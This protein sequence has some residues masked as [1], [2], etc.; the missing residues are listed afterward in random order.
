MKSA[1]FLLITAHAAFATLDLDQ[2]HGRK[3]LSFEVPGGK[4]PEICVIPDHLRD[5]DY[6]DKDEKREKA[7]CDLDF[8][9][10]AAVCPKL[11]STNPGLDIHEIP[12][13]YTLQQVV[14][15]NCVIPDPN[16]D[17]KAKKQQDLAKKV[18]KYKLSTSCSYTPSILSYYHLSRELG[19]ILNVPVAVLRTVDLQNH[20]ALG[21]KAL[22][23]AKRTDVIYQTWESLMHQLTLGSKAPK[24]D[25]LLTSS[26]DQSYGAVVEVPKEDVFYKEFF[27]G[28]ANG[29]AR[30]QNLAVKNPIIAEL[31]KPGP[32]TVD[33][34]FNQVNLQRLIQLRDAANMI[35]IDTLLSQEDRIGNIHFYEK[36]FYLDDSSGQTILKSV[37]E[38]EL[39]KSG[40]EESKTIKV[41]EMLLKD[42]DCGVN[43]LNLMSKYG[44]PKKIAHI[45]PLVYQRLLHLNSIAD[46][47]ETKNFFANETLFT[48][49]DY[50]KFRESLRG[51][52]DLLHGACVAKRLSLDLDL[53][54][55]FTGSTAATSCEQ[56]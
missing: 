18:A 42:N 14:D 54:A 10:T 31:S 43:R 25:L 29:E 30:I 11:N 23:E 38:K 39:K 19:D 46:Q 16:A 9:T 4:R 55:Y 24:K 56:D 8:Y 20:I 37:T 52:T 5:A 28:G 15:K 27:N 17:P 1:L 6:G 49:S 51:L 50:A 53:Q 21:T 3:T 48:Q 44:L 45:D 26:M 13:G 47:D 41:R 36:Y 32:L 12:D 33:H 22:K 34:E 2:P 35:V 7:L 40:I